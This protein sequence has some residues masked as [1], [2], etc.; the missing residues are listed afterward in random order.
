MVDLRGCD[1]T[2]LEAPVEPHSSLTHARGDTEWLC[3]AAPMTLKK[4]K[5]LLEGLIAIY[6]RGERS[7]AAIG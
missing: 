1:P 7:P 6:L 3:G 4:Y 2:V 5:F